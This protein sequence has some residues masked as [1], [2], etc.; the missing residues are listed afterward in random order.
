MKLLAVFVVALLAN[1]VNSDNLRLKFLSDVPSGQPVAKGSLLHKP[2]SLL[3]ISGAK[4]MI[5][6]ITETIQTLI[7][8]LTSII[9]NSIKEGS[10]AEQKAAEEVKQIALAALKKSSSDPIGAL[11]MLFGQLLSAATEASALLQDEAQERMSG[12]NN[13]T[14]NA[15]ESLKK[16]TGFVFQ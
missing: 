8:N 6:C 11:K 1:A 14:R 12:L 13:V 9:T 5:K 7:N 3:N 10:E 15:I 2:S 16:C 4:D